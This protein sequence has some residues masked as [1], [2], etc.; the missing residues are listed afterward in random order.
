MF[1]AASVVASIGLTYI[2]RVGV[3]RRMAFATAAA[4]VLGA[5]VAAG[6][7]A[8]A[9]IAP[10]GPNQFFAGLVNGS[11]GPAIIRMACFGRVV[12]GEK[13]HPMPGQTLEVKFLGKVPPAQITRDVGFTGPVGHEVGVFFGPLPPGG[14]AS[15]GGPVIFARYGVT[16]PIPASILLP[17]SGSGSVP[18]IPIPVVGGSHDAVVPV[19]FVGQP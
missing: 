12:P 15:T 6:S 2:L 18:F 10:I 8:A 4:V 14:A 19:S 16:K 5:V 13:G 17:C 3:I 7:G 9:P 11:T 1:I